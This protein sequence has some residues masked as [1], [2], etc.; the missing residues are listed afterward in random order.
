M[1]QVI[2]TGD[3]V[4]SNFQLIKQ[5][6][7]AHLPWSREITKPVAGTVLV[8][9]DGVTQVE[10]TTFA[11]SATTG[12]VSFLAGHVPAMGLQIT[13]GFAFDVP[14]RFDTDKLE[15][16]IQ[17]FGHGAIPNIPIVEVRL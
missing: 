3:G 1:D 11:V 13:A 9:V 5:Y 16:N 4:Q 17:G 7:G 14:V 2:G 8:A 6:G 12:V 10:D 15:V